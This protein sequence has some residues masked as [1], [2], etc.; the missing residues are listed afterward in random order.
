VVQ[1]AAST[2]TARTGA[3]VVQVGRLMRTTLE[4]P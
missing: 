2:T 3:T 4:G 1:V